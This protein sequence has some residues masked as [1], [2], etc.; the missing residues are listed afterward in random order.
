MRQI[1]EKVTG[2]KA[3]ERI[4]FILRT[5]CTC[6]IPFMIPSYHYDRL[7]ATPGETFY[8]PNGHGM[9]YAGKSETQKLREQLELEREK[10]NRE[11][12]SL[13]NSI[14]DRIVE[15]NEARNKLKRIEKG[16]CPCCNRTFANVARHMQNKHP[17]VK[18]K[19]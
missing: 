19:K 17:E 11:V 8:C 15:R 12:D 7:R 13:Q 2:N 10:H 1:V 18:A 16:V 6:Q 9:H 14:M 5:C 4:E 3:T